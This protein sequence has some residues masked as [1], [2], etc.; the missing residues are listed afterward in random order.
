MIFQT[1]DDVIEYWS[2]RSDVLFRTFWEQ[3]LYRNRRSQPW[4]VMD[5]T[6]FI[7]LVRRAYNGMLN[8][9]DIALVHEY[10][11]L[12]FENYM[13]LWFNTV[14]V[15]HTHHCPKEWL[16]SHDITS[17]KRQRDQCAD[18]IAWDAF[19]DFAFGPLEKLIIPLLL[20]QNPSLKMQIL[21]EII[22][23]T[24][25]RGDLSKFFV[26]NGQEIHSQIT[27]YDS[28]SDRE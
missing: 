11:I 17:T 6:K 28:I 5:S 18:W 1:K 15:G 12:T 4:Q 27:V 2:E 14:M 22:G 9:I 8:K 24:H 7:R 23:I 25:M 3:F 10:T 26:E 13:K 16:E 21:S 19:S 20:Q